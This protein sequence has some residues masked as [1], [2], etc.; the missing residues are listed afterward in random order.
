M[1]SIRNA[2]HFLA[3]VVVVLPFVFQMLADRRFDA[4]QG[5]ETALA[6]NLRILAYT[7]KQ[8]CAGIVGAERS[9]L[10]VEYYV[11]SHH[12]IASAY[13]RRRMV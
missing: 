13:G 8:I 11:H 10:P 12:L 6:G 1:R 3:V 4:P 9:L 7:D 5:I 2:G